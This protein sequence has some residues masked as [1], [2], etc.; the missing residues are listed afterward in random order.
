MVNS[1][2]EFSPLQSVVVGSV[3]ESS[4]FNNVKNDKIR[5]VLQR[6]CEE[7]NEDIETFKTTLKH[8]GI[9]T[10]QAMPNDLGYE[11]RIEA[12]VDVNG[13]IGFGSDNPNVTKKQLIPVPP[14]QPR[15]DAVTMGNEILITDHTLE[16][17]GYVEK[18]KEWFGDENVNDDIFNGN[19]RFKR[20]EKNMNVFLRNR[21][22]GSLDDYDKSIFDEHELMG[23]CSPNLT[24][25]GK[26]CLV[27]TWQTR[28]IIDFMKTT[29]P[30]FEYQAIDIGGHND[31]IFSVLKPGLVIAGEEFKPH[32]TFSNWKTIYFED[33][34]WQTVRYWN[35]LKKKNAGKWWVP[36]EE[37]NDEF[38][39]FVGTFL[40]DWTGYVE[41]T[42]FDVNCLVLDE[43]TVV[44]NSDN[45]LLLNILKENDIDAV[46]CPLRH[47]FFWDGG[48]HCLTLDVVRQ[49]G[50][51]D[52][53]L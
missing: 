36:G 14:L 33:P 29:Y 52:Y 48:W 50:Q 41:E 42:I 46:V 21:N 27:D 43:K 5:G 13:K 9:Q 23:F 37:S 44:V 24:R 18:F 53:G 19:H 8:H 51:D 11:D 10:F 39:S 6:I 31:G 30:Q 17:S 47:R 7:T 32:N 1:W 16:I 25:I 26:K 22:M 15:D 40:E 34:N 28:D 4:F 2:D 12:Y 3:F 38:T 20:T 35:D 45:P 49:G